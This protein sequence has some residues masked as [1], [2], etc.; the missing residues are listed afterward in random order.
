MDI[1]IEQTLKQQFNNHVR[2]EERKSN[3]YQLFV[4]LYHEDGDMIDMYLNPQPDGSIKV[5]DLG[6]TLMRLSYSY[7]IDTPNKERIF[8][9]IITEN[10]L[11]VENG[12]IISMST[13]DNLFENIM[14]LYGTIGKV[15]NMSLFKREVVRSLFFEMLN[16][17]I[18]DSLSTFNPQKDYYPLPDHQEYKVD[19][20]FNSRPRPIYLY[21]VNSEHSARLATISC[22][23]FQTEKLNFRGVTVLESLDALTKNDMSRL[24]SAADKQFPSLEDF[25]S[26]AHKFLEREQS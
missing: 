9:Q 26:Q 13:T 14:Q 16:S 5:T 7:D 22:L 21:G 20:Y 23:K 12:E 3:V 18:M 2:L 15:S 6:K 19:Y 11:S 25:Q 4:P 24:M 1:Q 8:N 10:H 17:Y